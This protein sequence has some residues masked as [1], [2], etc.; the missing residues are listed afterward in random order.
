MPYKDIEAR[1]ASN[2]RTNK[3]Y[4]ERNKA[5]IIS[6]L[7]AMRKVVRRRYHL[8]KAQLAC[9][10]CGED[11]PST[12]DFH[13]IARSKSNRSISILI[14]DGH[15]WNRIMLEIEKCMVLCANCHRKHHRDERKKARS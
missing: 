9:T 5:Q 14:R 10:Q 11:D 7:L 12:L 1:R 6:K 3:T 15:V 13:H 8:Y 2:R 4:Y